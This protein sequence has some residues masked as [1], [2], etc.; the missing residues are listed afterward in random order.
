M[1]ALIHD[2]LAGKTVAAVLTNGKEL[3]VQLT[4]GEE[5]VI[6]W[7]TD[8]PIFLRQDVRLQLPTAGIFGVAGVF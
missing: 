1:R 4:T 7:N 5:V 8:G 3:I 6:G 2:R